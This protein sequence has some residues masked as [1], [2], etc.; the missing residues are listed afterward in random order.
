MTR[1]D[2][3][4]TIGCYRHRHL[5]LSDAL[6]YNEDFRERSFSRWGLSELGRRIAEDTKSDPLYLI[7]EFIDEMI[8]YQGRYEVAIPWEWF[9]AVQWHVERIKMTILRRVERR[10]NE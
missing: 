8:A 4:I 3:L 2:I 1:K 9:Y 6:W 5:P 10:K 7:D